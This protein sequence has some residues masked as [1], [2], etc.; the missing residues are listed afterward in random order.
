[1]ETVLS[2]QELN[3]VKGLFLFSGVP[4][5]KVLEIVRDKSCTAEEF[6]KGS[7]IYGG[8]RFRR[9]L[10]VVL[11]GDVNV[12]KKTADGGEI[13]INILH[14]G[15]VFG[16]AAIFNDEEEFAT[17]LTAAK[18]CRAAFLPQ[19]LIRRALRENGDIAENYI[20]YLSGRI[21]FL[22][23]KIFGLTA[24]TAER[25]LATYLIRLAEKEGEVEIPATMTQLAGALDIGRASLYRAMDEL[26][27]RGALRKNGKK[28]EI[29]D[30]DVLYEIQKGKN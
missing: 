17:V 30:L 5:R 28:I 8:Q 29:K 7:V 19:E 26:T 22:N 25:R 14:P 1:M 10:G 23:Q 11:R 21:I 2:E 15:D 9:S 27:A 16:A 20:R 12:T 18:D 24:G 3:M 6:P 4:E 13:P